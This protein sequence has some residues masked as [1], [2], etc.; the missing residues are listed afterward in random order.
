VVVAERLGDLDGLFRQAP[1]QIDPP[2]GQCAARL[3]REGGCRDPPMTMAEPFDGGSQERFGRFVA[4]PEVEDGARWRSPGLVAP[5]RTR[6]RAGLP[7]RRPVRCR[8]AGVPGAWTGRRVPARWPVAGTRC[9]RVRAGGSA[10]ARAA[11]R[12]GGDRAPARAPPVPSRG[13]R[14][15]CRARARA[16]SARRPCRVAARVRWPRRRRG[17][18]R[19]G[20]RG[21]PRP[22]Q[23][24]PTGRRRTA[25]SSPRAGSAI[26]RRAP[27]RRPATCPPGDP[28][29]GSPRQARRRRRRRPRAP[30]RPRTRRRTQRA[31]AGRSGPTRPAARGSIRSRPRGSADGGRHPEGSAPATRTGRRAPPAARR[32]W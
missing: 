27:R 29:R 15:G 28:G 18:G 11:W 9:P 1:G 6:G 4:V 5:R 17:S 25:E 24:P 14:A 20:G 3:E 7:C 13:R 22:R 31:G 8:S 16:G 10:T 21:S 19:G 32:S 26:R 12:R 30:P 2:G 23:P